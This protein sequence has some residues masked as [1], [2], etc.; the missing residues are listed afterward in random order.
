MNAHRFV[1]PEELPEDSGEMVEA[2]IRPHQLRD[3]IGQE[4]LKAELSIYIQAALQRQEALD[5]CLI[6]GPPGLGK[7]TLA[8]VVA[9]ELGVEIKTSSGP[10]IERPGDLLAILNDLQPGAILFIDEIHR[11]PRVVE[12][13]LYSAMEDFFVD[14]VVG[15]GPS[16]QSIHFE[17][18]P[19]TLI[20]AT[21]RA[22][23]L[24]QP[25]RD[26]FG[27]M[28]HMSYYQTKELMQIVQRSA[29][30]FEIRIDDQ[31]ASEIALRSRGTPRIANRILRRVRDFAQVKGDGHI[32]RDISQEALS[33][34]DI[35]SKGLDAIDR[36]ILHSMIEMYGGGPVGI[37][38]IAVNISEDLETI[39]DMYEPYLIQQGFLQRTPRGRVVTPAAYHHLGYPILEMGE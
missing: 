29:R 19:F 25:L 16:S 38:T 27:I 14:I 9:H 32:T 11:L 8:R 18:P 33:T 28:L 10:A 7:T 21:T 5:H 12:E 6:Y 31:G 34:L 37:S 26:R 39:E 36:K 23:L 4:R 2:K 1:S 15:Q 30:I 3:Y 22:G 20:G 17:L 35:D 24:S 13:V